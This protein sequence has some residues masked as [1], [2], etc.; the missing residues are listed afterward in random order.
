MPEIL[1]IDDDRMIRESLAR[2][3]TKLGHNVKEAGTLKEGL[4]TAKSGTFDIVF[5]DLQLPDGN[6]IDILPSLKTVPSSPEIII[7][8]GYPDA[9]SAEL[10]IRSDAWDYLKKPASMGAVKLVLS[11]ALQYREEK[12][13]AVPKITLKNL[14]RKGIVGESPA[15]VACL[16]LVGRAAESDA[17]VLVTGETGTGKELFSRAVHA[18]SRRAKGNF[19]VVDCAS[20]PETLIENLLFGHRKG[21]YTGADKAEEGLVKHADG[22]TLFLDEIGEL[23]LSSQK[24]FLRVLQERQFRPLGGTQEIK[25]DF[26][27]I[28]ASNRDLDA[29]VKTGTFREDL[30]FRLRSITIDL[31]PLAKRS[32]DIRDLAI[33]YVSVLCKS[34]NTGMKGFSPDFFEVLSAYSWPGNVRELYST[35]EWA[36]AHALL[37]PTLF[38]QHLPP[39]IRVAVARSSFGDLAPKKDENREEPSMFTKDISEN[40]PRWQDYRNAIVAEGEKRYLKELFSKTGKNMKKASQ[41]SGLSEPRLYQLLRKHN[42]SP[43]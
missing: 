33:N 25:S 41:L 13:N 37:E 40:L 43:G 26:R 24:S 32:G 21:A 23:T 12:K 30:L 22:G 8:T 15:I 5:L 42:I 9:E 36:V 17:N 14:E 38:H 29:M 20:M 11:R 4:S 27:L 16:D 28:S 3:F 2:I 10:A 6:G 34:Q 18:N 7:V 1:I 19:V 35:L 31:P 39:A